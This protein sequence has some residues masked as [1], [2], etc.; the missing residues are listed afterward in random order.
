M[1]SDHTDMPEEILQDMQDTVFNKDSGKKSGRGTKIVF[2]LIALVLI[3]YGA[4]WYAAADKAENKAAA[5]LRGAQQNG[6][7]AECAD[8]HKSGFPLRI[9]VACSSVSFAAAAAPKTDIIGTLLQSEKDTGIDTNKLAEARSSNKKLAG[10]AMR[11]GAVEIGAP[12]YAPHW[13][14][15]DFTSPV[16][17]KLPFAA[18]RA[19]EWKKLRAEADFSKGKPQSL[20]LIAEGFSLAD[21][22][23]LQPGA[24]I[25]VKF[26]RLEAKKTE[27][28]T[29]NLR[30]SFDDLSVPYKIAGAAAVLPQADGSAEFAAEDADRFIAALRRFLQ[31][32]SKA[33][34]YGHSV[35][36]RKMALHFDKGGGVNV[37]GILSVSASGLLNGKLAVSVKDSPALLR[38]LRNL[39]PAQA[40]NIESGF[41]ILSAVPKNKKGEPQLKFEIADGVIRMGFLK[42]GKIAAL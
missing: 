13:L 3:G 24:L 8:L 37:S 32:G 20:S 30:V 6:V 31:N 36:I 38:L 29:A 28:N 4:F 15:A 21:M 7:R 12:V 23:F 9:A 40:D 10:F 1:Q 35:T 26:L 18:E 5:F 41:F 42:L 19:A 22:P 11:G 27:E 33:E 14:S 16:W 25:K 39:F 2:L 34:W 17:L